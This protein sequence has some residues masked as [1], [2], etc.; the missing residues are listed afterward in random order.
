MQYQLKHKRFM[1]VETR[2]QE[3]YALLSTSKC[4]G[5]S[6]VDGNSMPINNAIDD[7]KQERPDLSIRR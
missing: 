1:L 4:Y 5:R 7:T 3:Q 2:V 6:S